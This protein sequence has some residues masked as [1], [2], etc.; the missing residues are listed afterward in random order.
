MKV[1][2][3]DPLRIGS[4]VSIRRGYKEA[5]ASAVAMGAKAYQYF[6]KN[7]RSLLVKTF[8]RPDAA[9]CAAYCREQD[10]LSI[11]HAPYPVNL[12]AVDPAQRARTAE[13]L[14]NDLEIADA[15]GSIGVVVHFGI[16][17]GPD[18]L[19]GYRSII[20]ALDDV[21]GQWTGSAKLLIENQAGDHAVMGTT[22]EE[23]VQIRSLS[24]HSHRIGFCLDTCHL[25]AAGVWDG[26]NEAAWS[27]KARAIGYLDHLAAVHLNDS[28]HASGARRDRHAPV[29]QGMIGADA[30]RRLLAIPE[31]R[32]I[33]IVLETPE[34]A[35]YSHRDQIR[36]AET[37]AAKPDEEDHS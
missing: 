27:D 19:E 9:R 32:G 12:A 26:T 24:K 7:P 23:L 1:D 17:K 10:L 28:V 25:F 35:D 16:Y 6:P 37:W 14:L 29:G 11:A 2:S 30:F 22:F 34:S 3:T 13:S 31:L 36:Q 33:P 18:I 20:H 21:L 4:H 8:D 5:A 15:C